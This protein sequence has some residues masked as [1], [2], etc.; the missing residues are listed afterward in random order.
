MTDWRMWGTEFRLAARRLRRNPLFALAAVSVLAVGIGAVT[1]VFGLVNATLLHPLPFRDP[2]KLQRVSLVVPAG[3]FGNDKP[4][5][6]VWSYP[7]FQSFRETQDLFEEVAAH[8]RS[9]ATLTG[10]D[11]PETLSTEVVG[12]AYFDILGVAPMIGRVF[13][14]EE[15]RLPAGAPVAIL[16][17]SLW[18]KR[19]GGDPS[20]LG[21][22]IELDRIG[23][24]VV[25][26]MPPGFKGLTGSA[27]VWVPL[28]SEPADQLAEVESHSYYVLG[29]LRSGLT[30]EAVAAR[31]EELARRLNEVFPRPEGKEA[32]GMAVR[33]L[34]ELR[35]E[36]AVRR[37]VWLLFAAVAFVLIIIC[38]NLAGL[39][40]AR[41]SARGPEMAVRRSL[42]AT[43]GRIV[44]QLLV[45][46]LLLSLLGGGLGALLA[47]WA[48]ATLPRFL[49]VLVEESGAR[50]EPLTQITY[51]LLDL[52][53]TVLLFAM[54]T[55]L[56]TSLFMGALP[57]FRL[58]KV[59]V[60]GELKSGGADFR[61]RKGGW[62]WRT[63]LVGGEIAL[64]FVLLA[65]AAAMVQSLIKLL[66]VDFGFTDK[67]VLTAQV[68]LPRQQYDAPATQAFWE[69]LLER[70][71]ALPGVESVGFNI[72]APLSSGCNATIMTLP[73]RDADAASKS[74][75][76][77]HFV[78][79]DYF[80]SLLAPLIKGRFFE[81][82]D[83]AGS[84]KVVL[85]NRAAAD[86]YWPGENP[87]GTQVGVWQGG[88]GDGAQVVGVV[89]DIRYDT[90][91]AEPA[92]AAYIPLFQSP[93]WSGVLHIRATRAE[94]LEQA[95]RKEVLGLDRNLPL[96]DVRWMS[97]RVKDASARTRFNSV[98]L[99]GFGLVALIVAGIGV[100]GV[101]AYLTAL[102]AHEMGIR[103]AL[104]AQRGDIVRLYLRQAAPAVA[105]GLALGAAATWG[106]SRAMESLLYRVSPTDP[107]T[108]LQVALALLATALLAVLAPSVKSSLAEPLQLLK[109]KE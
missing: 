9:R 59:N 107:N 15:D 81:K 5:D 56:L 39:I 26:V 64:T 78:N 44:R 105:G 87:V 91:D 50:G 82:T 94:G 4:T 23:F 7:K 13:V 76:G 19:F 12:A 84:P 6:F 89:G 38:V 97:D 24:I 10:V 99:A 28:T 101:T 109:P 104:G 1:T 37:S 22:K 86:L 100:Y 57:A 54:A 79:P 17:E 16:G 55:A 62:V 70:V 30:P 32:W 53:T 83:R 2:A 25:G 45:E 71:S 74:P 27:D 96:N 106:A 66:S 77:V 95:V 11:L 51:Q 67:P 36:P 41:S 20:V 42:G 73:G 63:L 46:S 85:V 93:R 58:A 108:L 69:D 31:A 3:F 52:D 61:N 88:F 90:I 75:V 80:Q 68:R 92:P 14:E 49:P 29:R 34:E 72:C 8:R 65:G 18:R 103:K 98:L 47:A 35:V 40:L 48:T 43:T 102:R 33:P 60:A 21:K